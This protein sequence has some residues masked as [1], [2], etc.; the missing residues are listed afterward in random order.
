[1]ALGIFICMLI[2]IEWITIIKSVRHEKINCGILS[3]KRTGLF[4]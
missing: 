2:I 3:E 4:N 1:M